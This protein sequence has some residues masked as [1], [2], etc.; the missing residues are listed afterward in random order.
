MPANGEHKGVLIFEDMFNVLASARKLRSG[1]L[2]L[3][4]LVNLLPRSIRICHN[5]GFV[6]QHSLRNLHNSANSLWSSIFCFSKITENR[7]LDI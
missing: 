6:E 1:Q 5:Y 4:F 2:V 7:G 3:N